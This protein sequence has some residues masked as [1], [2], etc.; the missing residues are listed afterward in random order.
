MASE[1]MAS[2]MIAALQLN[3]RVIEVYNIPDNYSRD[4]RI[5]SFAWHAI[6]CDCPRRC[7]QEPAIASVNREA[8]EIASSGRSKFLGQCV[9]W[10]MDIIYIGDKVGHL[11]N[12]GFLKALEKEGCRYKLKYLA[13]DL[14]CWL[15]IEYIEL[16]R[17][18]TLRECTSA[19]MIARLP[20]LVELILPRRLGGWKDGSQTLNRESGFTI[21]HFRRLGWPDD[22]DGY[23][24]LT[25]AEARLKERWHTLNR[26]TTPVFEDDPWKCGDGELVHYPGTFYASWHVYKDAPWRVHKAGHHANSNC[27]VAFIPTD[28]IQWFSDQKTDQEACL[29]NL[30]MEEFKRLKFLTKAYPGDPD[31]TTWTP[32]GVTFPLVRRTAP[33]CFVDDAKSLE[34]DWIS[35][36]E[37]FLAR[38]YPASFQARNRSGDFPV[39]QHYSAN[40]DVFGSIIPEDY[41]YLSL[42]SWT[43]ETLWT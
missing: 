3:A 5:N 41:N 9:Y 10:D 13:I 35:Y 14:D 17:S 6:R 27:G 22:Q 32:P 38:R 29:K 21:E 23:Q 34:Q 30:L 7:Y 8:R 11:H 24:P 36:P 12:T 15:N 43:Q 31:W 28:N 40:S 1:M 25:I 42:M 2:E 20:N 37:V 19:A 39:G 4:G 16:C 26:F 18:T 33:S